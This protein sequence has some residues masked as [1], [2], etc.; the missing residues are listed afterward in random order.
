MG[1]LFY[2]PPRSVKPRKADSAL[3]CRKRAQVNLADPAHKFLH[4]G[5]C[6]PVETALMTAAVRVWRNGRREGLKHLFRKECRFESDHPHHLSPL[7]VICRAV[8]SANKKRACG[9]HRRALS[10]WQ[11]VAYRPVLFFCSAAFF[12]ASE[13]SGRAAAAG[14]GVGAGAAAMLAPRLVCSGSS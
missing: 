2:A 5:R 13:I 8:A 6:R 1:R 14:A 12:T 4:L 7:F 3:Y 11:T 10:S 9:D